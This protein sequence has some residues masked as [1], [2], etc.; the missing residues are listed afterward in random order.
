MYIRVELREIEKKKYIKK[1]NRKEKKKERFF[2][3]YGYEKYYIYF[4]DR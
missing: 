1:F 2:I 4:V 3:Y